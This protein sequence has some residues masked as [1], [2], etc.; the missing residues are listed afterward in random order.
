MKGIM[1]ACAAV[2]LALML[3]GA[4]LPLCAAAEGKMQIEILNPYGGVDWAKAV[5]FRT[6]LHT[7]TTAS[8]GKQTLA[9]AIEN[10]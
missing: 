5:P 1:R 7:H 10:Y 2:V 3:A 6:Q 8:D 4:C 9:D